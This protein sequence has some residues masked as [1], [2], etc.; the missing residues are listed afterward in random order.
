MNTRPDPWVEAGGVVVPIVDVKGQSDQLVVPVWSFGLAGVLTEWDWGQGSPDVRSLESVRLVRS[1]TYSRNVPVHAFSM[2]TDTVLT[3][4]SGLEHVLLMLLD[5]QPD[6]SWLVAQ[7]MLLWWSKK[8]RHYPDL[9]AMETDGTVT[10][11]DARPAELQDID[12]NHKAELTSTACQERG[13]RYETF[14]GLSQTA[15]VNLRWL[16]TARRPPAWLD[17]ARVLLLEQSG[18]RDFALGDVVRDD[19]DPYAVSTLWHLA[20]SGEVALDLEAHW[21]AGTMVSWKQ[22]A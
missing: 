5:R 9:L 22:G 20:W 3:L 1:S 12:F 16:A 19:G 10:V 4:E 8:L 7:P 18:G 21:D 11:W 2:T 15:E 14:G 17:A 13:W 6:I